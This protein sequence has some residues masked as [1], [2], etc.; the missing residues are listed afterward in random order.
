MPHDVKRRHKICKI[1][2]AWQSQDFLS[3]FGHYRKHSLPLQKCVGFSLI[4]LTI[5]YTWRFPLDILGFSEVLH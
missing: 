2:I 3:D 5:V 4:G 1:F